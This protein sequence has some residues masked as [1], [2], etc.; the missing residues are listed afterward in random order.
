MR[1]TSSAY[2]SLVYVTP[3]LAAGLRD[4]LLGNRVAVITGALLM[5]LTSGIGLRI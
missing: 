2:A 3:I 4:R 5:T 1:S